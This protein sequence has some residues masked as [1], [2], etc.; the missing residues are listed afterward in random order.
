M[1]PRHCKK[2]A[3]FEIAGIPIL[4]TLMRRLL[5]KLVIHH[6]EWQR[7]KGFISAVSWHGMSAAIETPAA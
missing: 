2:W 1:Q 7:A 3:K 4:G 5:A 6:H